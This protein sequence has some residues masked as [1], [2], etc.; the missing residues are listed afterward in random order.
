MKVV[1]IVFFLGACAGLFAQQ[2]DFSEFEL[3]K[4]GWSNEVSADYQLVIY[5]SHR[6]GFCRKL[7]KD[8]QTFDVPDNLKVSFIEYDTD[9]EWIEEEGATYKE[10]N[11][12]VLNDGETQKEKFLP[13]IYLYNVKS[14]KKKRFK[15]YRQDTWEKILT[16]VE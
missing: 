15:G 14:G 16:Q 7:R 5:G 8:F 3:V 12:Y 1:V 11:V 10:S 2:P 6:C 9:P 4:E 13:M